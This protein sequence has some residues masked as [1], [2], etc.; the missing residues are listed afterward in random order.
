[1]AKAK[2]TVKTKKRVRKVGGNTGYHTCPHCNGTGRVRNVGR[3]AK[4][5]A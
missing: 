1:M 4:Y 2:Q 3:G 5:G